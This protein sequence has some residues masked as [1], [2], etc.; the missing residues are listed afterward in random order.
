[1][2]TQTSLGEFRIFSNRDELAIAY[3]RYFHELSTACIH[4]KGVM[5]VALAGGNT[6]KTI[7]SVLSDYYRNL[8]EWNNIHFFWGDERCVPPDHPES[9]YLMTKVYLLQHIPIPE[10]NIHRI[11]GE[12][13]PAA[14]VLR[15]GNLL[16]RLVPLSS[17]LPRLDLVMLGVGED[18]HTASIFPNQMQNILSPE[19]CVTAIHPVSQQRRVTLTGPVINNAAAVTILVSGKNKQPILTRVLK[20]PDAASIYPVAN[21]RPSHGKLIW[22]TEK[23][24]FPSDISPD[25]IE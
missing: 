3:G 14:E 10:D 17:R 8:I 15:Y 4:E 23:E 9:N 25:Q 12:Q 1:M 18:G 7:F 20:D 24:A 16:K 19:L 5:Y 2:E 6:P 22:F 11:F 21:I 13:D